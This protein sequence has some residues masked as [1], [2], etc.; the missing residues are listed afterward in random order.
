MLVPVG[1]RKATSF[2]TYCACFCGIFLTLVGLISSACSLFPE[3][4]DC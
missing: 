3:H 2:T 1:E 4:G